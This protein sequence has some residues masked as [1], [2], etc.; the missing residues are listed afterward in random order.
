MFS[1]YAGIFSSTKKLSCENTKG[2]SRGLKETES[3]SGTVIING[4]NHKFRVCQETVMVLVN[5]EPREL[6][7]VQDD[8]ERSLYVNDKKVCDLDFIMAGNKTK[9]EEFEL[10]QLFPGCC[11]ADSKVYR[12]EI[13]FPCLVF[14][15][16]HFSHTIEIR[17]SLF[18]YEVGPARPWVCSQA[19]LCRVESMFG[20]KV[21][22]EIIFAD[23]SPHLLWLGQSRVFVSVCKNGHN[24]RVDGKDVEIRLGRV[25]QLVNVEGVLY[26]ISISTSPQS[27]ERQKYMRDTFKDSAGYRCSAIVDIMKG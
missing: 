16:E 2:A 27:S 20:C 23:G 8:K 9:L 17:G 11:M 26:N 3:V 25:D 4:E 7:I 15:S 1:K 5:G 14:D 21:L 12:M 6:R 13:N 19:F 24:V 22:D 18:E 10:F